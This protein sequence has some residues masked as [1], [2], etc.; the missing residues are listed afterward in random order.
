MKTD[1]KK[2]LK[3]KSWTGEELAKLHIEKVINN[4]NIV[5]DE[6]LKEMI[7]TIQN[8]KEEKEIY[9]TYINFHDWVLKTRDEILV[10]FYQSQMSLLSLYNTLNN[11][12]LAE[13]HEKY[14]R[15]LPTIINEKKRRELKKNYINRK[16]NSYFLNDILSV[17]LNHY[18]K[19]IENKEKIEGLD[20][21]IENYKEVNP[22]TER[23]I[24]KH[25]E[26]SIHR[27]RKE[28]ENEL[29]EIQKK[30]IEKEKLERLK[31]YKKRIS[32]YLEYP[33]NEK[34]SKWTILKNYIDYYPALKE[35]EEKQS[36]QNIITDLED[37]KKEFPEIVEFILNDLEKNYKFNEI[38][39]D[40]KNIPLKEIINVNIPVDYFTKLPALKNFYEDEKGI[41]KN[42]PNRGIAIVKKVDDIYCPYEDEYTEF[43][44][45]IIK[46][47]CL[48]GYSHEDKDYDNTSKLVKENR[49]LLYSGLKKIFAYN[50]SLNIL[51]EDLIE[52]NLNKFKIDETEIRKRVKGYNAL[53]AEIILFLIQEEVELEKHLFELK[54]EALKEIFYPMDLPSLEIKPSKIKKAKNFVKTGSYRE[55]IEILTS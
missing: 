45:D 7:S 51:S 46:A 19:K 33:K 53:Y 6:K 1:I 23:V 25:K 26:I 30:G 21:I 48:D 24:K 37:F 38:K 55:I 17:H 36:K 43:Q 40:L 4:K 54:K 16:I 5:S 3:K 13:I 15:Q 52:I 12:R 27:N 8:N 44:D 31:E 35:T 18:I 49:E 11:C 14:K 2:I 39:K 32:E 50:I 42:E 10:Y 29:R 22:S 20:E 41:C 9:F 34:A 47:H 28:L